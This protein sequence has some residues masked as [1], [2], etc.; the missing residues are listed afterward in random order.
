MKRD[1]TITADKNSSGKIEFEMS[2][3]GPD[4]EILVF[5]KTKDGMPKAEFYDVVFT[6]KNRP[7][8]N[9]AF[10]T[11]AD[12]VMH[13]AKG[14]AKHLPKCNKATTAP[15]ANGQLKVTSVT[16]DTLKVTNKDEDECF[17]KFVLNFVDRDNGNAP[18]PFDPIWGNQNG[19]G[20]GGGFVA[21]IVASP[22]S[23][24]GGAAGGL[25]VTLLLNPAATT[26]TYVWGAVIGAAVGIVAKVLFKARSAP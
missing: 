10:V 5:N 20:G 18:V 22:D 21:D 23:A 14:S 24:L 6:L 9:L 17:Y 2:D 16:A 11:D 7:G 19:G 3:G 15:A 8:T 4:T 25:L 12:R 1:V 26:M 13:V